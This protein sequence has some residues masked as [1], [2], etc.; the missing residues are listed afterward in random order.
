MISVDKNDDDDD[1]ITRIGI[2]ITTK[3]T[4]WMR[5]RMSTSAEDDR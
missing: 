5:I 4:I 3:M 2:W 1:N